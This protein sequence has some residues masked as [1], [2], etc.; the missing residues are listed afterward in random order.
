MNA[1]IFMN[2]TGTA[3][4][5]KRTF[6]DAAGK[7][8]CDTI[9][10]RGELVT[11]G[12]D[13]LVPDGCTRYYEGEAR[14]MAVRRFIPSMKTDI[15]TGPADEHQITVMFEGKAVVAT[16]DGG[17]FQLRPGEFGLVADDH[18]EGHRAADA[19]G[20]GFTQLFVSVPASA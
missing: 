2:R 11:G 13:A 3:I 16:L 17:H 20:A 14:A 1:P 7:T 19:T 6:T 8:H 18:G 5:A 15:H 12:A 10:W 9:E 4:V